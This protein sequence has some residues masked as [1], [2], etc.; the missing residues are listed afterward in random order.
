LI[1]FILFF[2]YFYFFQARIVLQTI[3]FSD[4]ESPDITPNLLKKLPPRPQLH[5]SS[6]AGCSIVSL[7]IVSNHV[8]FSFDCLY[9]FVCFFFIFCLNVFLKCRFLLLRLL[10]LVWYLFLKSWGRWTRKVKLFIILSCRSQVLFYSLLINPW[11]RSW[12]SVSVSQPI[13]WLFK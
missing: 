4:D 13:C 3:P 8:L 9:L 1:N 5:S 10:L 2:S 11:R 6:K 7:V 12:L